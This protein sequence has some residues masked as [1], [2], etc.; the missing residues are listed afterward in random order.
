MN[1]TEHSVPLSVAKKGSKWIVR[2]NYTEILGSHDTE[3]AAMLQLKLQDKYEKSLNNIK[4]ASRK[5]KKS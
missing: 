1:Q 3:E 4:R 5:R 2:K